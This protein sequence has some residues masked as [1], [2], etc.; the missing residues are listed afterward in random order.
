VSYSAKI[1]GRTYFVNSEVCEIEEVS[2]GRFSVKYDRTTFEIV[3]GRKSGGA[4][5]EWYV[6]NELFFGDRPIHCNSMIAAIRLG[7]QY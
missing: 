2:P 7:I 4:R 3:G 1:N 5:H 6:V